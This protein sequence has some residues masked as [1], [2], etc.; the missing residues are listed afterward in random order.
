M[1]ASHAEGGADLPGML[2]AQMAGR[3]D[4]WAIRAEYTR[5]LTGTVTLY[6]RHSLVKNIGFDGSG[7]HC[8][9]QDHFRSSAGPEAGKAGSAFSPAVYV[10]K[11]I[12][13]A[14]RAVYSRRRVLNRLLRMLR[15]QG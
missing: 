1:R 10:D 3:I 5:F 14:F 7:R 13:A 15:L 11:R 12:A 6:P 9:K 4:S 8:G 2:D